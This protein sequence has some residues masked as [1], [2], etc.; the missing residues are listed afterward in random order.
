[1]KMDEKFLLA[2]FSA[3]AIALAALH[4]T[5]WNA[6]AK[7]DVT[8]V[9]LLILAVIPWLGSVIK[10]IQI[11]GYTFEA[12]DIRD[13]IS[14]QQKQISK[15]QEIT[16]EL[17]KRQRDLIDLVVIKSLHE[18]IY[19][20]LRIVHDMQQRN[21]GEYI[22]WAGDGNMKRDLQELINRDFIEYFD[23]N[24]LPEKTDLVK[25]MKITEVGK[26]FV[27]LREGHTSLPTQ[28]TR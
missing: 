14:Q 17:L 9:G 13:Q 21:Y 26:A 2:C 3:L 1:M 25:T 27:Q 15:Q 19:R 18:F 12:Q 16:E 20:H 11:P 22:L 23:V 7:V 28:Q 8:V 5:P 24:N 6:A 10:K 4:L